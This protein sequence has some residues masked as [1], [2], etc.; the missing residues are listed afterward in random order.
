MLICGGNMYL[1]INQP[2]QCLYCTQCVEQ[3]AAE[4][5]A[6]GE[7]GPVPDPPGPWPHAAALIWVVPSTVQSPAVPPREFLRPSA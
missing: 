2:Q 4:L 3:R 1:A 7:D 5:R 6:A